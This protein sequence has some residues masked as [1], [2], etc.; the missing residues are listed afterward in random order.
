MSDLSP[1]TN[2]LL[3]LARN[4]DD[5]T[6]ARRA[7]IKAGLLAQVAAISV[8]GVT[9][10]TAGAGATAVANAGAAAG[11]GAAAGATAG[12][13]AWLSS[14]VV[15]AVSAIALLSATGAGVY[16]VTRAERAPEPA[17][18][19]AAPA[20]AR[21]AL[22]P[23]PVAPS[24][25][26]PL[27]AGAAPL[28]AGAASSAP[29]LNDAAPS[30]PLRSTSS[31]TAATT[32]TAETLAEETRLLREADQALRAGN[33]QHAL[34]LLDEHANRYPRGALAPERNAERIIARCKLGQVD[35]KAA[36]AYLGAHANSAFAPRIRDACAVN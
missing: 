5:L 31:A 23:A 26:A 9:S 22:L 29:A 16:V 7:Q 35:A 11:T 3:A 8:I 13:L 33:A 2:E 6:A 14:S 21:P 20:L 36:R 34:A 32:V 30:K 15:K 12:K 10:A 24:E 19:V 18:Q 4:A 27:P 17:A 28:A 1:E 25:P